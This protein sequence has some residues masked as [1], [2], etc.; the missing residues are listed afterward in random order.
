MQADSACK[1][2]S[3]DIATFRFVNI[4]ALVVLKCCVLSKH[5]TVLGLLN[6]N[7]IYRKHGFRLQLKNK[8]E[9]LRYYSVMAISH[10]ILK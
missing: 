7:F 2:K 1:Q 5:D 6:F 3:R 10:I 9:I 4:I 8:K